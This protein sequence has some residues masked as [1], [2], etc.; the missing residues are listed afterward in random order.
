MKSE[1]V[2]ECLRRISDVIPF[3]Y[4]ALGWY[5]SPDPM[6]DSFVFKKEK[7][8][9][10]FMYWKMVVKKG[11]RMRFSADYGEACPG[12]A[13]YGGL[14]AL[15]DDDG[16][17]IA[18][19]E[20]LKKSRA[21]ARRYYE[22]SLKKIHHAKEKYLYFERIEDMAPGRDVEV[23][24]FFPDM[25]GMARLTVF[26]SYD[27][28]TTEDDVLLPTASGCQSM[29]TLPYHEQFEEK[30]KS[31]VGLMD[32]LARKF[33][34]AD[35]ISFSVPTKR[36]AEMVDN[37]EGSF[38]ETSSSIERIRAA[39]KYLSKISDSRPDKEPSLAGQ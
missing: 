29:F 18:D 2:Q 20:K 30:P 16:Y 6:E 33:I 21:L 19:V 17:F 26:S 8:V 25:L 27:R 38:L 7:W 14:S 10:M 34:P 15:T 39:N 11:K 36:L 3:H 13:E 35:M 23:V 37:I 28:E 4:P 32:P 9:C 5:F 22:D 12:P 1:E 24:N 31:V